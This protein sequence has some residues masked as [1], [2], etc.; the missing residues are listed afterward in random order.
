MSEHVTA[1]APN[2]RHVKGD[3]LAALMGV[4]LS[5]IKRW[6]REG[7]PSETWGMSRT[8]RY[9]P[10]RCIEWAR[11]RCTIARRSGEHNAPEQPQSKE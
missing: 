3:E 10:S 6:R 11:S 1:F 8:R 5:T 9:L 4:S 7:M 2:E